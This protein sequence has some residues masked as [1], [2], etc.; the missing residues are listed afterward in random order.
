[1]EDDA[2]VKVDMPDSD[3]SFWKP[4]DEIHEDHDILPGAPSSSVSPPEY[5]LRTSVDAGLQLNLHSVLVRKSLTIL[6]AT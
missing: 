6:A 4:L 3:D 2:F 1:M 5:M